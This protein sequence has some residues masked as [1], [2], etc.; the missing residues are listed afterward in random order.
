MP[1]TEITPARGDYLKRLLQLQ[2]DGGMACVTTGSLANELN[3]R[4]A[5]V[6]GMLERLAQAG[7]V[8]YH[9]YRGARLT[10]EGR[11]IAREL[12][13]AHGLLMVFLHDALGYTPE[14][15]RAE[16]EHLEHH[17]SSVFLEHL[18]R[19]MNSKSGQH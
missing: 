10:E 1:Q 12:V 6:T 18:E 4:D 2:A 16:A 17:V 11:E 5:S 19:W 3:V 13:R 15:A 9:P 8:E 7:W 14:A